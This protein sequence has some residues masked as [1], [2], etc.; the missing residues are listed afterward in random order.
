MT[1]NVQHSHSKWLPRFSLLTG[2]LLMTVVGMSLV[3]TQLWREVGPLRATVR[4]LRDEV[5]RLSIVDPTKPCAIRVRTKDELTWKWRLW[6]P[7]GRSFLLKYASQD[8]PAKGF[9]AGNGSIRLDNPGETWITYR[10]APNVKTGKWM[11]H[12]ETP[13]G[14]VGSSQQD[15][16]SWTRR[17]GSSE[18][19]GTTTKESK[20]GEAI[21][22]ARLRVSQ[23]APNS[24]D[25]DDPSAGFM[26]WLE[27]I[28]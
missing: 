17:M 24:A 11:D 14:S 22:L 23:S 12:L 8:V 3:I 10:I 7:E 27:P 26:I 6:I 4:L 25:I 13:S 2:L 18:G 19:V 9:P 20:I 15:W 28:K 1:Q 5:G 16:V 21:L